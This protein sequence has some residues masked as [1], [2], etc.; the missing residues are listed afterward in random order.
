ML[1][2]RFIKDKMYTNEGKRIAEE[3]HNFMVEFFDRLNN[4]VDWIW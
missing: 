3:R 4:E 2:L 1:N